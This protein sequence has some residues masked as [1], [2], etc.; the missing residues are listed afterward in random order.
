MGSETF[1]RERSREDLGVLEG[2]SGMEGMASKRLDV[3]EA[4]FEKVECGGS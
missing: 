2:G 3:V 1:E 4:V